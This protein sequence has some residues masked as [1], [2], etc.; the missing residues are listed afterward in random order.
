MKHIIIQYEMNKTDLQTVLDALEYLS[1]DEQIAED[2]IALL[3][4]AIAAP[5]AD[6][7][8]VD[9]AEG[10]YTLDEIVRLMIND[11]KEST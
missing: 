5:K 9:L 8:R 7:I 2:A 4:A 11:Q 6:P 1:N 3:Q 10:S